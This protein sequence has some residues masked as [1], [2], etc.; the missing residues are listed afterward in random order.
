LSK[1]EKAGMQNNVKKINNKFTQ[2]LLYRSPNKTQTGTAWG[3]KK[4]KPNDHDGKD[5]FKGK[6]RHCYS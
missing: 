3:T 6:R 1:R 2:G 5:D 4:K